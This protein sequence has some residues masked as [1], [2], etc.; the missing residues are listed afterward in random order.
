MA[1]KSLAPVGYKVDYWF[2]SNPKNRMTLGM[3]FDPIEAVQAA[4][5]ARSKGYEAEVVGRALT[6]A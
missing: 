4:A 2:R 6:S 5:H 3:T 1:D